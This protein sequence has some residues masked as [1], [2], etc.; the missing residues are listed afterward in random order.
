M[1]LMPAPRRRNFMEQV[2][3][4]VLH[5]GGNNPAPFVKSS[6]PNFPQFLFEWHPGT[7]TPSDGPVYA[8]ELPGTWYPKDGKLFFA[9]DLTAKTA[10]GKIIAEHCDTEGRF[11]GFVQ[12]FLRGY[13]RGASDSNDPV[14]HTFAMSLLQQNHKPRD[15]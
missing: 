12:T 14:H 3:A 13:K 10:P 6:S 9:P 1:R 2:P 11:L 8:V 5:S 7:N 15:T 4:Q